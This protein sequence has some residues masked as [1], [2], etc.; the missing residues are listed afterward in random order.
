MYLFCDT[1]LSGWWFGNC[2]TVILN[3]IYPPDGNCTIEMQPGPGQIFVGL[4]YRTWKGDSYSAIGS[5]MM[6][7]PPDFD[8]CVAG[9][10]VCGCLSGRERK[11]YFSMR[12]HELWKLRGRRLRLSSRFHGSR[13][14]DQDDSW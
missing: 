1:L 10:L 8:A 14:R 4:T 11:I 2:R 7:R 5:K 6:T 9:V 13:M 12:V 3:G